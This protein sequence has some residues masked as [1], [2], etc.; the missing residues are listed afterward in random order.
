MKKKQKGNNIKWIWIIIVVNTEIAKI[1]VISV[2]VI[3]TSL[4]QGKSESTR[5]NKE[6]GIPVL[7][8]CDGVD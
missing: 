3:G 2:V 5:A 6:C 7:T 4:R 1:F 8:A